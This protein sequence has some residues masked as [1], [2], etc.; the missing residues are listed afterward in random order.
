MN[1]ASAVLKLFWAQSCS[2]NSGRSS[3]ARLASTA[4]FPAA[5]THK[6]DLINRQS[7]HAQSLLRRW[8]L[9]SESIFSRDRDERI[10]IE[11]V[12]R[13]LYQLLTARNRIQKNE[14]RTQM[15]VRWARTDQEYLAAAQQL[16]E[17]LLCPLAGVLAKKR[18]LIV[19]DGALQLVPVFALP[20]PGATTNAPLIVDHEVVNLPSISVLAELR[21]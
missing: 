1:T 11:T 20:G 14:A 2:R 18:L 21:R 7:S 15:D 9:G 12:A 17:M 4:Q 16:S 3:T 6:R 8:P 5:N 19:S 10:Q 13:R